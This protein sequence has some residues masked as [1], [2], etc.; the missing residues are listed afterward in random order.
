MHC[1][2]YVCVCVCV[3]VCFLNVVHSYK[4]KLNTMLDY[5]YEIPSE[6]QTYYDMYWPNP[7][8]IVRMWNEIHLFKQSKAGLNSGFSFSLDWLPYKGWIISLPY[9]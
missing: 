9:Y 3:G 4:V 5:K 6:I 8:T 1:S 2:I 7:S